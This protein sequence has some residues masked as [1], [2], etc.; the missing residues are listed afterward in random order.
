MRDGRSHSQTNGIQA[1]TPLVEDPTYMTRTAP[2]DSTIRVTAPAQSWY[3]SVKNTRSPRPAAVELPQSMTLPT[4]HESSASNYQIPQSSKA[5][6]SSGHISATG[7]YV[8]THAQMVDEYTRS[9]VMPENSVSAAPNISSNSRTYGSQRE[10]ARYTLPGDSNPLD[11]DSET[12]FKGE[13]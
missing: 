4:S 6:Q 2:V 10:E 5:P 12:I 8:T 13:D 9:G 1:A 11:G 7:P 3:S